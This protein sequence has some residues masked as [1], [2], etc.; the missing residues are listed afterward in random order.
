MRG[1]GH[2]AQK[3]ANECSILEHAKEGKA[4]RA[5]CVGGLSTDNTLISTAS[6]SAPLLLTH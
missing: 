5:V 4:D 1:G 3:H 2:R 6:A